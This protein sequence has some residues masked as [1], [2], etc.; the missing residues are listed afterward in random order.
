M[1][2]STSNAKQD[3]L[4]QVS[5]ESS[6]AVMIYY[7]ALAIICAHF[8]LAYTTLLTKAFSYSDYA[9]G[10]APDPFQTRILMALVFRAALH[11][12]L[13]TTIGSHLPG[14]YRDP[15]VLFMLP[16]VALALF[17]ATEATR[18][19]AQR[20]TGGCEFA[21][22]GAFLVPLMAYFHYITISEI[23]VQTPYDVLQVAVFAVGLAAALSGNRALFYPVFLIGTLNRETTLFLIPIFG[24]L[25]FASLTDARRKRTFAL[26]AEMALQFACWAALRHFSAHFFSPHPRY[27]TVNW[28]ANLGFMANPMHWPTLCSVFAFLWILVLFQFRNIDHRGLR[29]VALLLLPWFAIM[30]VAGDLLEIR[31]HS[32]WISYIAL[33]CILIVHHLSRT[34]R[35]HQCPGADA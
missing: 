31:I 19:A 13:L 25:E 9:G 20:L 27:I 11:L 16:V 6:S 21:R 4:P 24:I 22:W 8:A 5:K 34:S 10:L 26:A 29:Y 28:R 17:V 18:L 7:T 2:Y 3:A 14:P 30:L 32:E 33:C 23:R 35:A 12:R 15:L 1:A